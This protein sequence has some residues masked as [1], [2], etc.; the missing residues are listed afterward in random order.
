MLSSDIQLK[1]VNHSDQFYG[2]NPTTKI[3]PQTTGQRA[4]PS[5]T[6]A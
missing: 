6:A 5:K 3:K 4:K 1:R 2:R